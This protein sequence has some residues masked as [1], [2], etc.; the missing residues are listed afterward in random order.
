[1]LATEVHPLQN[2]SSFSAAD[3]SLSKSNSRRLKLLKS[4]S[5]SFVNGAH[6]PSLMESTQISSGDEY[7]H[8]LGMK[9]AIEGNIGC[10]KSTALRTLHEATGL[11]V[12]PEPLDEWP[13]EKFY[14]DPSRYAFE[15][16]QAVLKSYVKRRKL[17][18]IFERCPYSVLEVFW[19]NHLQSGNATLEEDEMYRRWYLQQPLSEWNEDTIIIYI[20]KS[21]ELCLQHMRERQQVGDD[22]VSSQLIHRLHN[23]YEHAFDVG[24]AA[25]QN[26]KIHVVDG[27]LSKYQ[28]AQS[29]LEILR[30]YG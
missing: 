10:G 13:L 27:N 28:V 17:S 19:K 11:R 3:A 26:M 18:G 14:S 30:V 20:R 24:N 2:S 29:I 15:M 21:P 23:L 8:L 25:R 6:H 5:T 1:M 22:G 4:F 16:Q 7:Q 12:I 9:I